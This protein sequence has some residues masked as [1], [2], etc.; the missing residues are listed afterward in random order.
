MKRIQDFL[1]IKEKIVHQ[2]EGNLSIEPTMPQ[3]KKG[4]FLITNK[5]LMFFVKNKEG[6]SKVL[7]IGRIS[8]DGFRIKPN[9]E[10]QLVMLL[11]TPSVTAILRNITFERVENELKIDMIAHG[12]FLVPKAKVSMDFSIDGELFPIHFNDEVLGAVNLPP[13]FSSLFKDAIFYNPDNKPIGGIVHMMRNTKSQ[14]LDANERNMGTLEY[15]SRL[16]MRVLYPNG[17][18]MIVVAMA[19]K[20]DGYEVVFLHP[21]DLVPMGS[22]I[23]AKD[24]ETEVIKDIEVKIYDFEEDP[25]YLIFT[26]IAMKRILDRPQAI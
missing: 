14:F 9:E 10:K 15:L 12:K 3:E 19:E 22:A 26:V 16:S 13:Y 17:R 25:K 2:E 18:P 23:L 7:D 6:L 5:R 4:T 8:V 1:G 24:E 21:R 20:E 11:K